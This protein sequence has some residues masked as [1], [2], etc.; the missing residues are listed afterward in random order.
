MRYHTNGGVYKFGGN[1][2]TRLVE[3]IQQDAARFHKPP[4]GPIGNL[5]ALK[6]PRCPDLCCA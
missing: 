2:A 4:L 1:N 3:A 5:M 6:D